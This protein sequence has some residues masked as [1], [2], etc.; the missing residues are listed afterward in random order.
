MHALTELWLPIL[1]T[2]VFIFIASSLIHMVFKWHNSEYK[3]F[4]NEDAV[5]AAIRAESPTAGMYVL[6]YCTDMK[7]MASEEMTKKYNE[8]P[9]GFVTL[10]ANGMPNMGKCLGL[11]FSFSLFV[12]AVAAFLSAQN[13]GLAPERAHMGAHLV[14]VI[15]FIAYGFGSIQEG[16]WMGKPLSSVLKYLL[17]SLIYAVISAA[18]FYWLWP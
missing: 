17:D 3:S 11:W 14:A 10:K 13:V 15:T 9:V 6:P 2:S 8:G 16:I 12:A 4:K 1:L 7:Q 5:R 18:T